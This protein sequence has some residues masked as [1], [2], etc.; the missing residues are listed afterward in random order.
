MNHP[1]PL[2]KAVRSGPSRLGMMRLLDDSPIGIVVLSLSDT[3]I[4]GNRKARH[5]F[6]FGH[7][8]M[9]DIPAGM[10]FARRDQYQTLKAAFA[11]SLVLTDIEAR[12]HRVAAPNFF[13]RLTWQP[14]RFDDQDA[15]LLWVDD[16][17]A[18]VIERERH[19][20][21]FVGA[22][23][24]MI[25]CRHPSGEIMLANGRA[26]ELLALPAAG[27]LADVIGPANFRAL[28]SRLR[29]GGYVEDFNLMLGTA[30]GQAFPA[31][32]SAQL[33]KIGDEKC[34]LV[35]ISD[36]TNQK[37]AE[38]T[39][40]RFFEAAPL[41]MLLVNQTS[42]AVEKVNRRASELLSL[43]DSSAAAL[44]KTLPDFI[45]PFATQRFLDALRNG[46]FV[47][48]F[49][50]QF[51]TDY[52]ETF[53]AL[54]SGQLVQ[55][56]EQP[57]ILVGVSDIT[58]V[59]VVEEGL[60]AA[61][62]EAE[63][64]TQAKSM[65]LATMSHEIRTPMNGVLGM[66]DVLSATVLSGEQGEMVEVINQSARSLLA[67]IDDILD[68]SK[69]EAGKLNLEQ[70][71][72]KPRQSVEATLEMLAPRAR[73]RH[74]E[75]AWH[76]DP[77]IPEH[78]L[79]DPVRLRQIMINLLG[80]AIKFTPAGSVSL[81]IKLID[82]SDQWFAARF[83]VTD[84]GIGL[85]P[86]QQARLFQPFSQADASTTRQFGGT[87]LGLSIC[88]RLV[89]VMGGR[90]GVNST[91][92]VGSTFWFEVPLSLDPRDH[93]PPE[94]PLDQISLVV[95]DSHPVARQCVVDIL[96]A[97]GAQV[98]GADPTSDWLAP[99]RA[100]AIPDALVL[101]N[102]ADLEPLMA[103]LGRLASPPQVVVTTAGIPD[104]LN[105]FA[106][107]HGIA[108]IIAKPVHTAALIRVIGTAL[109][110]GDRVA[111][112]PAQKAQ[113]A[114]RPHLSRAQAVTAGTLILVAEDNAIN[115][116]VI[117]K[118]L[119]RLGHTYDMVEDG[120]QALRALRATPYGLLL[121]DCFMPVMDGYEL[122]RNI[123]NSE[124]FCHRLPIVALT[125]NA[126]Q[127]DADKCLQAGMDDY[128]SKPVDMEKLSSVVEKWL[129]STADAADIPPAPDGKG[130]GDSEAA[131]P[132]PCPFDL[133]A[134]AALIGDD[135]PETLSDIL[136]FFV[137][138]YPE[139][140]EQLRQAVSAKDRAA[141]RNAAHA[142]KG[143]ARNACTP[144]LAE[145]LQLMEE[146]APR[147]SLKSLTALMT[148]AEAHL[149]DILRH[150]QHRQ[151]TP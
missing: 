132:P 138:A 54:L 23:L 140:H 11:Q 53:W 31:C 141:I 42:C 12:M 51:T 2:A 20:I 39:L 124:D 125:A 68:L 120:E 64:A 126:L 134:L 44:K 103:Q 13:A 137:E 26:G 63:R 16:I 56:S 17:T 55:V 87:G 147:G 41:A 135:S 67:I 29:D 46:G 9:I 105:E 106:H 127:G 83:E 84:T 77:A 73:E 75:L 69:I 50:T 117:G 142:A 111:G 92:G 107:R 24:P 115:R 32:L 133:A 71:S 139:V 52:G 80:N 30:Y 81:S 8:E 102:Q 58:A 95:V 96:T 129:P 100:G 37:I 130:K 14:T 61:K 65:F 85:S 3:I 121:T 93:S 91:Q 34:I 27:K 97:A 78:C 25:L 123:R 74:L 118:Q 15:I 90:I 143:A 101:D 62:E 108:A 22:P 116:L 109:G 150:V 43:S 1:P 28:M 10:L 33:T 6:G 48:D 110:R 128:L 40:R 70:V 21:L 94:R 49:E 82:R 144:A 89:E 47:D 36:I 114:G 86:E 136:N 145:T 59:K 57:S 18:S 98:T 5:L 19:Q 112:P 45:G 119:D 38:D 60:K 99:L 122:T 35:G 131:A 146:K 88:A 76:V 104:A 7:G 151:E 148:Q 72:L 113:A 66:L 149:A 79:G 4:Y